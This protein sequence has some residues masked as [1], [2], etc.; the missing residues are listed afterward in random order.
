MKSLVFTNA[1]LMDPATNLTQLGWL[2]VDDG[3]IGDFGKGTPPHEILDKASQLVDAQ[4]DMLCPGLIDLRSH[5]PGG[6][7]HPH[8]VNQLLTAARP[9]GI[10]SLCLYTQVNDAAA[11][12]YIG[13]LGPQKAGHAY[14]F[15]PFNHPDDET[16]MVDIGLLQ[17]AGA[18]AFANGGPSVRHTAHL[19]RSLLY[20][21]DFDALVCLQPMDPYLSDGDMHEG[22]MATRLGLVGIPK[23]AETLELER[24]LKLIQDTQSTAHIDMISTRDAVDLLARFPKVTASVGIHHL[25]MNHIDV[26]EYR[27]FA[28][29]QPPLRDEQ[30]RLALIEAVKNRRIHAVVSANKSL[31]EDAKRVPFG[32]AEFGAVGVDLLL[33]GMLALYHEGQLS[34]PQAL[35]PLTAGP[36]NILGIPTG[37]LQK[38]YRADLLLVD[39]EAPIRL[40]EADGFGDNHPMKGRMLQGVVKQ[41]FVEG[42]PHA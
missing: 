31:G 24:L 22:Q 28:K 21:R 38:G 42:R 8:Q 11:L 37:H 32:E 4:G 30:D 9:F 1:L 23:L 3:I 25:L 10:T 40:G 18:A 15:P 26:G 16:R 34:L 5:A 20:A 29:M 2:Y 33:P 39:V 36:A 41:S 12:A 27:T 6:S 19:R 14:F 7:L 13:D 17:R 35:Y